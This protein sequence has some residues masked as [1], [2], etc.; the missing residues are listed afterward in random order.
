[1]LPRGQIFYDATCGL[2]SETYRRFGE[3][4]ER[5]GF[6]WIPVQ[7][8]RA[9]ELLGLEEGEVPSEVKLLTTKGRMLGGV[10][11]AV[12][13]A[14][15]IWWAW[16]IWLV[17]HLPGISPLFRAIYRRI[18]RNRHHLSQACGFDP[19]KPPVEKAA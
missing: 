13:V 17:S 15:S 11:A 1:M 4:T 9:R 2:C 3:M 12:H 7:D 5:R 18:A 19:S 14:K 8:A 10:D 6:R 16:P